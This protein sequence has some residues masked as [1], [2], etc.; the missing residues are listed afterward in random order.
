[1]ALDVGLNTKGEV[2][3]FFSFDDDGYYWFLYPLIE[4][5]ERRVGIRID[6]YDDATFDQGNINQLESLV[7]EAKEMLEGMPDNWQVHC[8]TQTYPE[9]KE[10]YRPVNL[11]IPCGLA[12]G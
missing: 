7:K 5:L 1:M 3:I 4:K 6:L 12:A 10:I 11:I 2:K 9:V 8:G